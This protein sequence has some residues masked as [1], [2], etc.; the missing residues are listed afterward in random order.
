MMQRW[1]SK[2]KPGGD[3]VARGTGRGR[4]RVGEHSRVDATIAVPGQWALPAGRAGLV[5]ALIG[6]Q[7]KAPRGAGQ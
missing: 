7:R 5:L 4:L 2:E 6:A 1:P 3:E